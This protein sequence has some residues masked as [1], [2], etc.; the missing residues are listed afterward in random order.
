MLYDQL[1]VTMERAR[2]NLSRDIDFD[3]VLPGR[4]TPQWIRD[5]RE[6]CLAQLAALRSTET[7]LG[8]S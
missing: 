6:V 7:F 4:L 8:G 3:A 5:V 1:F 2:W